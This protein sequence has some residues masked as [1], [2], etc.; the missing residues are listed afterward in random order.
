MKN[1]S[2]DQIQTRIKLIQDLSATG[3]E[4]QDAIAVLNKQIRTSTEVIEGLQGR[5]N[6]LVQEAQGFI[7][8]VHEAQESYA[9]D[10]SERWHESDA[11][12]AHADWMSG[13][14]LD[15][16]EVDV[17]LPEEVEEL[18]LEA[19]EVLRDLPEHP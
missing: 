11:G 4:L 18:I 3:G 5:Y 15:L 9:G 14:E 12:Q 6:E 19:V 2:N 16:E 1:L 17:D 13:W 8:S 10:R 7:E